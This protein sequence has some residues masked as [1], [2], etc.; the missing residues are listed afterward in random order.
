MVCQ[1]FK[2]VSQIY[3]P[4]NPCGD[5]MS[6]AYLRAANLHCQSQ[7]LVDTQAGFNWICNCGCK[8]VNYK[9]I[10]CCPPYKSRDCGFPRYPPCRSKCGCHGHKKFH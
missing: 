8:S 2:C 1:P 9:P 7:Y 5:F 4:L 6:N 3:A 10:G